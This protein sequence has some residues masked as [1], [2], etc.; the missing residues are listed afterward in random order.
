MTDTPTIV[1][2]DRRKFLAAAGGT[3]LGAL[4]AGQLAMGAASA[5]D[6]GTGTA[7]A[8]TGPSA[9]VDPAPFLLGVASGDPDEDSVVLWTR[10]VTDPL[11]AETGGMAPVPVKVSWELAR[12]EEFLHIVDDGHTNAVPESA[13][14]V[15]VEARHLTPDTWYWYRF[16]VD[17]VHSRV[18]RTRTLPKPGSPADQ[19]R[20]AFVS[21]QSWAGGH[22]AAYRDLAGQE[23]DFVMHL[24]DYIYETADGSLTEFRR[25]HAL[26]KSA[27]ELRDAHARF[28]FFVTWDDHE[29]QN[30]YAGDVPGGAGDGRPFLERRA[31]GYQAYYEHLPLRREQRPEGPDALMYRRF[32]FGRLAEFSVLDTRQ[33]RTDQP[34]GDGRKTPCEAVGDPAATLTG[35]EQEKWL[36]R[37]LHKSSAQW[38]VIAQQTI[39]AAFDYDLGPSKIVNLDQWDGYPAARSRILDFLDTE[40]P[41]N[42]VVLSG[43]WHTHWVND[44]K[45]DFDDPASRTVATEFVGTSISS[46]AGW[47]ADV[48]AGL[49]ANPHVKFYNGTYRGYV[50]CDVTPERWRAD[51]RIV[52]SAGDA[53]SPAYTIAAFEVL[54]GVPGARRVDGAG[55]GLSGRITDSATG[56]PLTNM[57]VKVLDS[58][59]KAVVSSTTG[60][61]GE[62]L[63]F[64]VPGVYTVVADGVGY[65]PV[66]VTATVQDGAQTRVTLRA[67]R[68]RARA[69]TGTTV[70]GPV[71]EGLVSDLVISND[72]LAMAISA[73]SEDSQLTPVTLGKPRDMAAVG[74]LDQIDWFNLPYASA[75]Q[76]RGSNA[77]QQRTVKSTSVQVVSSTG[78]EA[79]IRATG[80]ST[81]FPDVAVVTEYSVREG[82]R[83][84]TAESVF[85]NR[86]TV[87]RTLWIGDVIDH[88]GTGQ[89]SGVPG[90]GTITTGTPADYAPTAPWIGMTGA[91]SQTYGLL[92]EDTAFTA[93]AC[94]IWAMSQRQVTIEPGAAWTLRRRITAVDNRAS[95]DPFAVLNTL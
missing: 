71:A 5:A 11:D 32:D 79:R 41:Q 25:L 43:D 91:D 86:G 33:Y 48:R 76:P 30:N 38:N 95:L 55:D 29:V 53:A 81:A 92:Y 82:E 94:D 13:H 57:R 37:G 20:F 12:D 74:H 68:A 62:F 19:L 26:Y 34:C 23:L 22:F 90:H 28:P 69:G 63:A 42:P 52:L 14:S 21:C 73:G 8:A 56:T 67:D 66:Q 27:P 83:W 60:A 44:L 18:G 61:D 70:P 93:Y 78:A 39:M 31:N 88:D 59:G 64:A 75:A 35:P 89:R 6:G 72:Q 54:D 46:G 51:L 47:D 80:A 4:A 36:L 84:I 49:A 1:P 7:T 16:Q 65:D 40:R 87:A 17:G 10:L 9:V 58:A 85:T 77:W 45:K 2:F 15:H 24:G 50:I 3:T